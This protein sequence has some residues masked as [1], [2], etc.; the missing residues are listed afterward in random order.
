MNNDRLKD[1]FI[2]DIGSTNSNPSPKISRFVY[3]LLLLLKD[4]LNIYENSAAPRKDTCI[5]TKPSFLARATAAPLNPTQPNL[6]YPPSVKLDQVKE[7]LTKQ[8]ELGDFVVSTENFRVHEDGEGRE[9]RVIGDCS[10]RR[11][12]KRN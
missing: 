12:Q 8:G 7:I 2:R 10:W 1:S 3:S 4:E 5:F 9:R 6:T 11:Q